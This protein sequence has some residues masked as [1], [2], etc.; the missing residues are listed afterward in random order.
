M[1]N[2]ILLAQTNG[3]WVLKLSGD[4]RLSLAPTLTGFV[5]RIGQSAG[6]QDVI[7][8]LTEVDCIDSTM[9]GMLAKISLRS[10]EALN[11]VP[12]I[13]STRDDVTRI[14]LSMGFDSIFAIAG[15]GGNAIGAGGELATEVVSEDEMRAQVIE[16]HRTLMDLNESNREAFRDL[17]ESLESEQLASQP[18][19]QPRVRA[20]R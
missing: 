9:L 8:D 6:M 2:K 16:A 1:S 7:I 13:V 20:A 18:T 19:S 4:L 12:T 10:Q 14:L 5:N 17:V 11:K 3:T 15:E